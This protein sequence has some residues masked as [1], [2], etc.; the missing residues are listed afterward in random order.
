[1]V[2]PW[3]FLGAFFCGVLEKFYSAEKKREGIFS[4]PRLPGGAKPDY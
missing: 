1:V 2:Q 3:W 4:V